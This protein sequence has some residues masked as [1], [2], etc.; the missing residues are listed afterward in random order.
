MSIEVESY[1]S[2][3][4]CLYFQLLLCYLVEFLYRKM[5]EKKMRNKVEQIK[6]KGQGLVEYALSW[7]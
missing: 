4:S 2:S 6:K 1:C 5:E 3:T 7:C